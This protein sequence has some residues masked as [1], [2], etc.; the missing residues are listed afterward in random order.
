MKRKETVFGVVVISNCIDKKKT[1]LKLRRKRTK[2]L[3]KTKIRKLLWIFVNRTLE[4]NCKNLS[5]SRAFII[6]EEQK[7]NNRK[8][9]Q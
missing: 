3:F 1:N 2:Y 8:A 7:K 5:L 6:I 9:K 4:F